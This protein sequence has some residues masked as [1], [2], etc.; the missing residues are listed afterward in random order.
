MSSQAYH[1]GFCRLSESAKSPPQYNETQSRTSV[2]DECLPTVVV[3]IG[4][5]NKHTIRA[6][7]SDEQFSVE[8]QLIITPSEAIINTLE[9][10]LA[11]HQ[12][13]SDPNFLISFFED[14]LGSILAKSHTLVELVT[15]CKSTYMIKILRCILI[16]GD[17]TKMITEQLHQMQAFTKLEHNSLLKINRNRPDPTEYP[18]NM[19]T[20]DSNEDLEHELDSIEDPDAE[21]D[22]QLISMQK[23]SKVIGCDCSDLR[24]ILNVAAIYNPSVLMSIL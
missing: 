11:L 6:V 13:N 4:D 3:V 23:V 9:Q 12:M 22:R 10:F 19:D 21:D 18:N 16:P 15:S 7:T 20:S 1:S 2:I 17:T 24:L 5:L 14:Q 8:D